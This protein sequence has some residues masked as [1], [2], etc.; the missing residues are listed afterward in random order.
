MIRDGAG[1][2]RSRPDPGGAGQIRGGAGLKTVRGLLVAAGVAM[3]VFAVGS[4][5]GSSD[6]TA[7]RHGLFLVAVVVADDALL[8]PLF[9]G[10]GIVV[11]RFVPGAYRA[12]VQGGLIATAA[13]TAVALPLML[14]FGR[15]ADIPSALPRDYVGG[16][17]IVVGAIWLV[18]GLW[19]GWRWKISSAA[20]RA[21]G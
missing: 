10:V 16:F 12:Y 19:I 20:R 2:T 18:M 1:M 13:V 11:R 21:R 14:G 17:A 6:F 8:I 3:I 5:A 15:R 4:A 7:G 9:I